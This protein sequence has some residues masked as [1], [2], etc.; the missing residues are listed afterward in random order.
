MKK[1]IS[2]IIL[3]FFLATP[4]RGDNEFETSY[5]V[6]YQ[7]LQNGKVK[8]I[9]NI[10]L[11]NRLSSVYATRYSLSLKGG[12]A[13][14]I[15]ANDELGPLKIE[16]TQGQGETT[17]FL[18]FNKQVVGTGKTLNFKLN[19]EISGLASK[20]G[21]I[22][23]INIPRL[24]EQNPPDNY[25]LTLAVSPDLGNPA[26]IRPNPVETLKEE[27]FNL[28][29]FTKDQILSSGV[30]A[31]FGRFQIFDFSLFYHLE[32]PNPT[33]AETEIALPPDTSFQQ[34]SYNNINPLPLKIRLDNDGNWLAKFKFGPNQKINVKVGGKVKIFAQPRDN[35][36][37]PNKENLQK[38][39]LPQ[40]YWEVNSP[41][42]Q[43]RVKRLKK[44]KAIYDYVINTLE[45]DYERVKSGTQRMGALQALKDPQ[46]AI[47]TEYTDL[48]IAL[49][50]ASGIPAR[51]I[52]GFAYTTNEKMKPLG[53]M[54]DVLHSWPEYWDEERKIWQPV[55]P[56]W[57]E[58]TGG[59]DYFSKTDLNHFTFAIHGED[60]QTPYPAGSYKTDE[61]YTRDVEVNF[62]EYE[63]EFKPAIQVEFNL[64]QNL[65]WGFKNKGKILLRNIG[66]VALYKP[67]IKLDSQGVLIKSTKPSL[68]EISVL[69]PFTKEEVD[70]ELKRTSLFKNSGGKITLSVNDQ[71]Y[72]YPV[73]SKI[74]TREIGL[75]VFLIVF[76]L[77]LVFALT[78]FRFYVKKYR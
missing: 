13:E 61:T 53:M 19:Y 77:I 17:I 46:R 16:T 66:T 22:W 39:L 52:N 76:I 1:I 57:G 20:N 56:T 69:L 12:R 40:K 25:S 71:K 30:N 74:G 47:C 68:G 4:V 8:V 62:G 63:G 55:D 35:F 33:T 21:Q 72:S 18:T 64:P 6:R 51:E 34:V 43:S 65:L 48:F 27:G 73:I 14:N 5:Q 42:I 32:N 24:Q 28:Y 7:L 54:A 38:N 15:E 60:S 37:I 31:A 26:Y 49:C 45:Y 78:K 10:S 70:V 3:F 29:R 23:E 9:Q 50:R 41:E 11:T 44:A 59:I 58:T 67:K 36:L 75:L 2:F